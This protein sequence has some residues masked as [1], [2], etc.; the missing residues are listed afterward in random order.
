MQ[1]L[2]SHYDKWALCGFKEGLVIV[3]DFKL[4]LATR[5]LECLFRLYRAFFWEE[6]YSQVF[7]KVEK[8]KFAMRFI[9]S[10]FV[11]ILHVS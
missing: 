11:R 6:T 7:I 4:I 9:I 8:N 1:S 3:S 10:K 5:G 2:L